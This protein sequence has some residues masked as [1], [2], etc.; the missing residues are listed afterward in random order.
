MRQNARKNEKTTEQQELKKLQHREWQKRIAKNIKRARGKLS[1]SATTQVY[2]TEDG[3]R[4]LVMNKREI[5]QACIN[6]NLARFTQ[7]HGTPLMVEPM[8]S[9]LGLLADTEVAQDI[10]N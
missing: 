10:L 4:R 8:P 2:V 5:E 7:S 6:R 1:R 9:A 3:T